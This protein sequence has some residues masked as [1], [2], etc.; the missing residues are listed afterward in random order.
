[1]GELSTFQ[2]IIVSASK[3]HQ[4]KYKVEAKENR[5]MVWTHNMGRNQQP[6]K[7]DGWNPPS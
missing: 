5:D 3:Q 6:Q 7:V 2:T 4:A 1:M